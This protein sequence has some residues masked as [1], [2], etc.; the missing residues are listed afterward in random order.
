[1][2]A[3]T[4][5]ATRTA[6]RGV[7]RW[8]AYLALVVVFAVACGLL[9]WW[10]WARR[11]ETID[12]IDLVTT[13]F[14]ARPVP[15][16]S[17]IGGLTAWKASA[18]WR[19]VTVHGRYLGEDQL[20]ARNRPRNDNPGFEVLVPFRLDDGRVFIVDRGWL[21]IGT[22]Q[23]T[24]DHVPAAPSGELTV[25]ARLQQS[26]PDLPGRTAPA[27]Q[28]S[29]IHLPEIAKLVG[30]PT[31]TGAYGLLDT[32]SPAVAD[33]PYPA[34]EPSVDE[35][36]HLSYAIQWIAFGIL[37]FAGLIWAYRRERRISAMPVEE[38]AAARAPRRRSRDSDYEDAVLDGRDERSPN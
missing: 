17:L 34:L 18:E 8:G 29:S 24:P 10:Q 36:P 13:N 16:D 2:T 23:D 22:D 9:S 15:L 31:Y 30:E 28:I 27:G 19:P 26:E 1:V 3:S 33:R 32:E 11:A 5:A 37:A 35:G 25:T 14:D 20:L 4:D 6:P 38:Q 7:R 21:P 12:A